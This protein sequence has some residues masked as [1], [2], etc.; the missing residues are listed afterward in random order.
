MWGFVVWVSLPLSKHA[1]HAS[2]GCAYV[3]WGMG[4]WV[5]AVHVL[6]EPFYKGRQSTEHVMRLISPVC[7]SGVLSEPSFHRGWRHEPQAD[8]GSWATWPIQWFTVMCTWA[9]N[10]SSVT[11][12]RAKLRFVGPQIKAGKWELRIP[13]LDSGILVPARDPCHLSGQTCTPAFR[14]AW[15][16]IQILTPRIPL[17]IQ[18][19]RLNASSAG[20]AGSTPGLGTKIP[21]PSWPKKPKHRAETT[22]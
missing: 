16:A 8:G 18:L 7:P 19:L 4:G 6:P 9:S 17:A 3:R 12:E 20:G 15:N 14:Q 1:S 22:L 5:S 11:T 21:H 13:A 10:R 2:Q